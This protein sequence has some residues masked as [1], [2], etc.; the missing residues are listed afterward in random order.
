MGPSPTLRF[1]SISYSYSCGIPP[2]CVETLKILGG[3]ETMTWL[4]VTLIESPPFLF[5]AYPSW[6]FWRIRERELRLTS[7]ARA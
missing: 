4:D 2:T 6:T 7:R 5:V 3:S 1:P